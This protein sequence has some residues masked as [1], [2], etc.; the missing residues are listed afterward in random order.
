MNTIVILDYSEL[1]DKNAKFNSFWYLKN[2]KPLLISTILNNRNRL[3]KY[4]LAVSSVLY[5][6]FLKFFWFA[7]LCFYGMLT[8]V[9]FLISNAVLTYRLDVWFVNTFC[10]HKQLNDQTVLFVTIQF[11]ISQQSQMVP[12]IVMYHKQFNLTSIICLHAVK[13]SYSS[14]SI[15]SI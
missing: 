5:T 11:S 4:L 7:L 9:G 12:S 10:W 6:L 8:I 14:I 1:N 3:F 13:W 2:L 15:N